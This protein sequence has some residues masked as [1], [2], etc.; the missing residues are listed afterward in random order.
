M[1]KK[2]TQKM[3][4]IVS[5]FI[6]ELSDEQFTNLI[7]GNAIIEYKTN[8]KNSF[9]QIK[10]SVQQGQSMREVEKCFK[11]M[12]KKDIM[13]FCK[14]SRIDFR[15]KD[16]KKELYHKIAVHFDI[17]RSTKPDEK[18]FKALIK[19]F[20]QCTDVK[21]AVEFLSEAGELRTKEDLIRFANVLDV[22]IRPKEK[23]ADIIHRIAESVVGSR[24]RA[25]VIKNV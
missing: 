18:D 13:A 23:K 15:K 16:T 25:Q 4:Q 8:Y 6:S 17:K 7:N 5:D 10:A 22:H 21:E 3:I 1:G 2:D 19:E 24:I 12:L 14:D 20:E 11:G 9:D